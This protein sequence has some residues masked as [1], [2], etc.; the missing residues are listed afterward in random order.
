MTR[1]ASN[2]SAGEWKSKHDEIKHAWES[3]LTAEVEDQK[4]KYGKI[5]DIHKKEWDKERE[6]ILSVKRACVEVPK[7]EYEMLK[8]H[9]KTSG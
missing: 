4:V 8:E 3:T 5:I 1:C 2:G 9:I 6:G 7:S